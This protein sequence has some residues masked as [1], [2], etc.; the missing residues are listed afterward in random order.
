MVTADRLSGWLDIMHVDKS[1]RGA[2]GLIAALRR[3]FATYGVPEELATDGGTEFTS[4]ETQQFLHDWRVSH[5]VSSAHHPQ[6]NGRAEVAVKTAKRYLRESISPSGSLDTDA[7]VK[8]VLAHK[9]TPDHESGVSPAEV[10]MGKKLTDAFKFRQLK[11][12]FTDE[13]VRPQWHEAWESK[14]KA[15]RTRFTKNL[16]RRK[17][18]ALPLPPLAVG[19]RVLIQSQHGNDPLRWDRSGVVVEVGEYDSYNVRLDG[20]GRLSK[21]TRTHLRPV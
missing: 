1:N 11:D 16:E 17:E 9:N 20:S 4:A 5:R 6:S 3:L 19:Q 13:D 7:V 2:K 21:R 12:V 15:F 18:H 10:V 8:A 14:E